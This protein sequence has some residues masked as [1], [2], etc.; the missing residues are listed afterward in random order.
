MLEDLKK[1]TQ[2]LPRLIAHE[3]DRKSVLFSLL[4]SFEK[5][6]FPTSQGLLFQLPAIRREMELLLATCLREI[7]EFKVDDI[8]EN[9]TAFLASLDPPTTTFYTREFPDA[10]TNL[11]LR[12]SQDVDNGVA[13][14][15]QE[16]HFVENLIEGVLEKSLHVSAKDAGRLAAKLIQLRSCGR[17]VNL[18]EEIPPRLL[19][20]IIRLG[21]V[22]TMKRFNNVDVRTFETDPMWQMG[23]ELLFKRLVIFSQ[24]GNKRECALDVSQRQL[25]G[26]AAATIDFVLLSTRLPLPSACSEEEINSISSFLC[27]LMQNFI[28]FMSKNTSPQPYILS[29]PLL[30]LRLSITLSAS[31][32]SEASQSRKLP[33]A[34]FIQ[35]AEALDVSGQSEMVVIFT[36]ISLSFAFCHSHEFTLPCC[37]RG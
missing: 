32:G 19:Q 11:R 29:L 17:G 27:Y 23:K 12:F 36:I 8:S 22:E 20:H 9:M 26:L 28:N 16:S 1:L 34:T 5:W 18:P 2:D 35:F 24:E 37:G 6:F 4:P 14:P 30:T 21:F 3:S 31:G 13:T 25:A 15:N 33:L 7:G 10:L